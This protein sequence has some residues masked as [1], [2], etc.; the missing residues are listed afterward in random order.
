MNKRIGNLEF[1][2][3]SYLCKEPSIVSY[4]IVKWYENEY[5]GKKDNYIKLNREFYCNPKNTSHRI[6]ADLFEHK[7]LNY[8]IA[9]FDWNPKD[10]CYDFSYIGDRPL[11]LNVK[12]VKEFFELIKYGFHK[13]NPNWYD[14]VCR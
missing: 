11:T 9:S 14:E 2:K 1:M 6:H 7:E 13:L 4:H 12:E 10:E 5:Y 8:A 3:A